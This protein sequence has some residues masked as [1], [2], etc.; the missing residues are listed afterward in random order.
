MNREMFRMLA[1]ILLGLLTAS[2]I[3]ICSAGDLKEG[4]DESTLAGM[5]AGCVYSIE[6]PQIAALKEKTGYTGDGVPPEFKEIFDD[7]DEQVK[8]MCSCVTLQTAERWSVLE[9]QRLAD[10]GPEKMEFW[11]QILCSKKCPLPFDVPIDCS[12]K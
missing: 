10:S 11:K 9:A 4:W 1:A 7:F 2:P 3:S 8:A 12:A 6:K 5:T